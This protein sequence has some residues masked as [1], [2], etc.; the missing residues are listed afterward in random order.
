MGWTVHI[1]VVRDRP[2][3]P[4]ERKTLAAHVRAFKL[5]RR[6]EG[7]AFSVAPPEAAGGVVATCDG[8]LARSADPA[9][10]A[11][12]ARLYE[13]LSGL[14]TL[15][16]ERD[17]GGRRRPP[18]GRLGRRALHA[19]PESRPGADPRAARPVGLVAGAAAPRATAAPPAATPAPTRGGLPA[20]FEAALAELAERRT[21]VVPAVTDDEAR[22]LVPLLFAAM[23]RADKARDGRRSADLGTLLDHLPA[24][25]VADLG[26][27]PRALASLAS[28]ADRPGAGAVRRIRA[29]TPS[30][31]SRSGSDASP[32]GAPRTCGRS[33]RRRS[34]RRPGFRAWSP[35]SAPR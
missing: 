12:A 26:V 6:S 2:L 9:E 18:P 33:W 25:V 4:A 30:A 22:A 20:P 21:P 14:R 16:P 19:G 10:D 31:C 29:G 3:S 7:Y 11:D 17:R 1:Q 34:P 35:A 24:D 28:Y 5:S 13:A 27:E 23:T 8:K 15:L 32:A